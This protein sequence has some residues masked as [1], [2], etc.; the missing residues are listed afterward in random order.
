[1]YLQVRRWNRSGEF[2]T[3][4][5][6]LSE[7]LIFWKV[8]QIY[9]L[10]VTVGMADERWVGGLWMWKGMIRMSGWDKLQL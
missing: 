6:Y 9:F 1:M 8:S 3:Q 5:N 7:A 4:K 10:P 2:K